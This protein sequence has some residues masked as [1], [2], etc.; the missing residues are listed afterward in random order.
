MKA[1]ALVCVI[2]EG[3]G[4]Q[5]TVEQ[6]CICGYHALQVHINADHTCQVAQLHVH[7]EQFVKLTVTTPEHAM[8]LC[9]SLIISLLY[10]NHMP[11]WPCTD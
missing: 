2:L 5:S 7:Y 11:V 1:C 6:N 10:H 4:I 9:N 3:F 8:L